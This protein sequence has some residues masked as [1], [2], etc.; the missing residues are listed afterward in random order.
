MEEQGEEAGDG[1]EERGGRRVL[2]GMEGGKRMLRGG[3]G[4]LG[5]KWSCGWA[6]KMDDGNA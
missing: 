2:L 4:S 1:G 5:S 3:N 6:G